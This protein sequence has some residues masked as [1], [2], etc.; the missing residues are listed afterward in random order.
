MYI[1]SDARQRYLILELTYSKTN[2]SLNLSLTF[3]FPISK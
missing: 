3:S 2:L 1:I